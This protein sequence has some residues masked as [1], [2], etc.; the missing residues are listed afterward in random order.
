MLLADIMIDAINY[1]LA[2]CKLKLASIITLVLQTQRLTKVPSHPK[3]GLTT[4]LIYIN[5]N[6]YIALFIS[7]MHITVCIK[8]N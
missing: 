2:N 6:M 5:T 8:L 3:N 1:S 4:I 7:Y